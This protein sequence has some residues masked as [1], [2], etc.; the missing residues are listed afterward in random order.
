MFPDIHPVSAFHVLIVPKTHVEDLVQLDN[1]QIWDTILV[2]V[3][4][5]AEREKLNGKGYR[6]VINGGGA[7]AINHLHVHLIGN[8][9]AD[10]KI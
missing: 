6:L 7:Q 2:A 9:N 10:R 3:K 8:I 4:K 1:L 5:L